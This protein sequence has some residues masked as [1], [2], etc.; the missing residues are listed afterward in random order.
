M[1]WYTN[2]MFF[3]TLFFMCVCVVLLS[4]CASNQSWGESLMNMVS[5]ELTTYMS[6]PSVFHVIGL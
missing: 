2:L 4:G 6:N 1:R 3:W 5:T